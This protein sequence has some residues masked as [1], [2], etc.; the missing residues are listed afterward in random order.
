MA[1]NDGDSWDLLGSVG[2]TATAVAAQRA[3][4][5]ADPVPLISDPYALPLVEALG[6]EQFVRMARGDLAP[7]AAAMVDSIAVR[8]RYFDDFCAEAVG[9][10]IRQAVIL[11][12]GLDTRAYRLPWPPGTTV[13]EA[14][15]ADVIDFKIATL[16][17]LGATPPVRH[18]PIAV[19][20]RDDWPAALR[21]AG[22]AADAPTAWIAEGLLIYLSP[23]SGDRLLADIAGLSAPGSRVATE[24]VAGLTDEQLDRI[25]T[26]MHALQGSAPDR[27][28]VDVGDLWYVGERRLASQYLRQRGWTVRTDR[29]T[30]LFAGYGRSLPPVRVT[31]FGDPTYVTAIR[32]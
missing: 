14:D 7:D 10:G 3:L 22:F 16:A 30:E 11:A 31:P 1:R 15:R 32:G 21:A 29:T 26:R 17:R 12:S 4:A 24:D 23:A 5:S 28:V 6:A 25:R 2:A 19:D 8:T 18:R 27:P 9:A 20:L 13:F